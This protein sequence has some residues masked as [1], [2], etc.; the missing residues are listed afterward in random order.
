[1]FDRQ[2]GADP[3]LFRQLLSQSWRMSP[4]L[5]DCDVDVFEAG[6]PLLVRTGAG[7]LGWWRARVSSMHGSPGAERLHEIQRKQVVQNA[8]QEGLTAR[9]FVRLKSAGI[10]PILVKGWAI[11]RLYPELGLRP[12]GDIDLIVPPEREKAVFTAVEGWESGERTFDLQ[13]RDYPKLRDRTLD[14]LYRRSQLLP[15]EG[16]T[17]RVL[18]PEDHLAL[19]CVHFLRH[20]GFRPL[21]LCDIALCVEGAGPEFDWDICL[22]GDPLVRNWLTCAIGLAHKLLGARVDHVPDEA[23]HHLPAWLVPALMKQWRRPFPHQQPEM[24]EPLLN[25]VRRPTHLPMALRNRWPSPIH[26]T[27]WADRPFDTYPRLPLQLR[28]VAWRTA[29][30]ASQLSTRR[31]SSA[32]ERPEG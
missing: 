24:S 29:A 31:D 16:T 28:N 17:V 20:G 26:A 4:P 13:D 11:S 21:W 2:A 14:D 10:E 5:L 12:S 22:G 1:M 7:G 30:Y 18:S 27:V 8:L 32:S 9:V 15:L 3:E 23:V 25:A 6:V 19:I